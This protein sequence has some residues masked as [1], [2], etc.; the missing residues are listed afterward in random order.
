MYQLL[1]NQYPEKKLVVWPQPVTSKFN[2]SLQDDQKAKI[3][4]ILLNIP[5]PRLIYAGLGLARLNRKIF[6]CMMNRFPSFHS[7]AW[8]RGIDNKQT[9]AIPAI[10][11]KKCYISFRNAI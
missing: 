8:W 6:R 4:E 10:S 9:I 2:S 1:L 11:N 3:D 5:E 7:S